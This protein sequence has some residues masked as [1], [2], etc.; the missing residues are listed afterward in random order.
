MNPRRLAVPLLVLGL[1]NASCGD[2]ADKSREKAGASDHQLADAGTA[3]DPV[4]QSDGRIE[5]QAKD[6]GTLVDLIA[7]EVRSIPRTEFDPAALATSLG[8]DPQRHFEWVRDNTWWAPY[9][10]LLRGSKGVM[11][12]RIGSSLDRAAL[13]GELLRHAGHK[14]RL[15]H[16]QLPET[17]ARALLPGV[18]P[19]PEKRRAAVATKPMT[20]DRQR[21]FEDVVPGI[22]SAIEEQSDATE[23]RLDEARALVDSQSEQLHT[24]VRNVAMRSGEEAGDVVA[25]LQD[26]WWVEREE[27]GNWIAMDVLLPGSKP[28]DVLIAATST[29]DWLPANA[30]PSIP[31]DEFHSVQLRIVVERY[32]SGT[33]TESTILE[34]TL[35]PA[36]VFDR[37]IMLGHMPRD[38]P[39]T[40]PD[41]K[42]NPNALKY[43]A[44]SVTEWVP[45]LQVGDK[46]VVQSGFTEAGDLA[47]GLTA[48]VAGVANRTGGG[49]EAFGSM[50]GG[51][52]EE[53]AY[54]TAEWLDYEVHVPGETNELIRRPVFDLLGPARR[55]ASAADFKPDSDQLKLERFDAL[56]GRT[57][58]LLQPCDLTA[59][60]V[61][62]LMSTGVI[63]SLEAFRELAREQDPARRKQLAARI[64][65]RLDLWGPLPELALWRGTL[66]GS[67][68]D[69][70]IDRPNILNYRVSRNLSSADPE[71]YRQLIDVAANPT[72]ARP[73]LNENGF[74]ARLRQ[75]V[76]DT[77]AEILTLGSDLRTAENTASV[78][79]IAAAGNDNGVLITSA[80]SLMVEKLDWPADPSAR[81]QRDL[82]AGFM[83]LALKTGVPLNGKQRVGW[84]RVNSKSGETIGVMDNGFHVISEETLLQGAQTPNGGYSIWVIIQNASAAQVGPPPA[85]WPYALVFIAF[86][87]VLWSVAFYFA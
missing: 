10:G 4:S 37:P 32:Q 38:W 11:L 71:A 30:L 56:S 40:L 50:L 17:R 75:G 55:A 35:R 14:I 41:P 24:A 62:H 73:S 13:L 23:K 39:A 63:A 65:G 74:A 69:T 80:D 77:V 44:L 22:V 7:A 2:N 81:L 84:W 8:S 70:Y 66:S 78:F 64:R 34:T 53:E 42:A 29:T 5:V 31:D 52:D 16:A 59:E 83:A 36:E 46:V 18:R 1:L 33:S 76:A 27:D 87:I 25:S 67:F 51:G 72:N 57:D 61:V 79:R 86:K 54:A 47:P 28:G 6:L 48:S 58:V 82:Q 43:A 60:F 20:P 12:D 19:I 45:F 15:A 85:M 68:A 49:F 26:H 21:A 3:A 9:R